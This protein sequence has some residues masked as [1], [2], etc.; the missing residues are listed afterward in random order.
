MKRVIVLLCCLQF[1]I[2]GVALSQRY[3]LPI[4]V[5]D[6]TNTQTLRV[7]MWPG[8]TDGFDFG[9]DTL[10]PP[11]P[12]AGAFD[13]RLRVS[14]PP[15]DFFTDMRTNT[16]SPRTYTAIYAPATGAGPIVLTWRQ[17]SL[18]SL[19]PLG[20]FII[21]DNITGTLYTLDMKTTGSLNTSSSPFITTSLR[22]VIT[23]V[24][25]VPIQLASFNATVTSTH[26]VLLEWLTL[27]EINNYGF[28]IQRH[29]IGEEFASL[30]GVFIQGH[31]TT[32]DPHYYSYTDGTAG[33]G[34]WWYRLKQIDLNGSFTFGPEVMVN[35]LTSVGSNERPT[36]FALHQNY[37]NPFNPATEISYAVPQDVHV[38]LEVFNS[39][40][41][42]VALL[43][44]RNQEVGNYTVT[45]DAQKLA[46]GLYFY[47][48]QAGS[49]TEVR[50]LLLLK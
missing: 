14:S 32:V 8:A 40:G 28:E 35:T 29:G 21:T 43:V 47:R 9:L 3:Q 11:A 50:K 26:A 15:N 13:A 49:F 25:P 33:A 2:S 22:I 38:K 16:I 30:P 7:G 12:P 42:Q 1:V 36:Q 20:T 18:D 34:Q 37:P 19:D 24:Q 48:M 41:Q 45:F 6:G 39:F 5:T 31:G 17:A 10:A 44:D 27:S 46:S 4:T 23:P